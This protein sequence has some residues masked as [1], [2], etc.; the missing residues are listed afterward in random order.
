VLRDRGRAGANLVM[1]LMGAAM[2]ALFY[3]LTLYLQ[4]VRGFSA[5]RTGLAYLPFTLGILLTAGGIGP[6]LLA[7]AAPRVVTV[8]GLLLAGGATAWLSFLTPESGYLAV[9]GPAMLIGGAGTGLAFVTR[10]IAP[11]YV[12]SR[13]A[14]PAS[15]RASS[16]PVPRSAAVA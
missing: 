8:A 3:L 15:P 12:T 16:T 5:M 4:E 10:T 14:T 6:R 7:V 13:R 11:A 1:L 2:L 9:L